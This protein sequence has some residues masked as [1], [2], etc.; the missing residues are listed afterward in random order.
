MPL[1]NFM[2]AKS[3]TGIAKLEGGGGRL[4]PL[5]QDHLNCLGE[6][7]FDTSQFWDFIFKLFFKGCKVISSPE[8][9]HPCARRGKKPPSSET[10]ATAAAFLIVCLPHPNHPESMRSQNHVAPPY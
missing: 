7:T 3:S 6:K 5:P 10:I 1:I 9:V 8:P 2:K 4:L